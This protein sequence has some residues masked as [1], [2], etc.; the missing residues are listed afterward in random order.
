[1]CYTV[2]LYP[3]FYTFCGRYYAKINQV[4]PESKNL[5]R[6]TKPE[7]PR[8]CPHPPPAD[9]LGYISFDREAADLLFTVLSLRASRKS[10]IIT[11]NLTFERWDEIFGDAAITSVIVDRLTYKA[12]LGL[13]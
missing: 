5:Q 6:L 13:K 7:I 1:M 9:E 2:D 10:T 4:M 3:I 12:K 11:L 8:N